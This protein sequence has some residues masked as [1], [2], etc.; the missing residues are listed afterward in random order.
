MAKSW[1]I[2]HIKNGQIENPAAVRKTFLELKDGRYLFEIS[3][4]NKRSNQQNRYYFGIVVPMIQKGVNDMGNEFT[5]EEI[6]D[7]LKHKFNYKE[8]V[9]EDT[10]EFEQIPESTTRL[11]KDEFSNYIEAIQ[12]FAAEFLNITIPDPGQQLKIV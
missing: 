2:V 1:G 11:T 5:Q 8:I 3:N 10:G 4:Y 6:H 9:N 7:W 12:I